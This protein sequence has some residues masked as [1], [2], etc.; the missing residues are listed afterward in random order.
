MLKI[1]ISPNTPLPFS[2]KLCLSHTSSIGFKNN[3][4]N[5]STEASLSHSVDL[6][7][8]TVYWFYS[9]QVEKLNRCM[10]EW[11]IATEAEQ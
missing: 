4:Q 2:L 11:L 8:V 10:T 1:S 6:L 3:E 7:R 5:Q 9:E